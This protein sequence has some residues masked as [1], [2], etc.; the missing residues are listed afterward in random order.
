[1]LYGLKRVYASH[2]DVLYET[3]TPQIDRSG[4]GLYLIPFC[5]EIQALLTNG[6]SGYQIQDAVPMCIKLSQKW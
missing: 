2:T 4:K 1:M 3:H 5:D 6:D